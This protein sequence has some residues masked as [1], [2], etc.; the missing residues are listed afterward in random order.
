MKRFLALLAACMLFA[1]PALGETLSY[2]GTVAAAGEVAVMTEMAGTVESVNVSAGDRVEAGAALA[3]IRTEKVYATTD[4]TVTGIFA[5]PGDDL[6]SAVTLYGAVMYIEPSVRYT[7]S[8][9]T[10]RA[11]DSVDMK[12]I[13]V[14]ETV[15]LYCYTHDGT[16]TGTG[17][18]TAVSGSSYTVEVL[19]GVFAIGESVSIF[20]NEECTSAYR[21]GRGTLSRQ[22]PTAVSG[23]GAMVALHVQ[24]GDTVTA[25]QLLFE[26]V[27]GAVTVSEAAEGEEAVPANAITPAAS[28]VVAGV[29]VS[30]G[31]AVEAGAQIATL[32]PDGDM[33]LNV[34]IP[35]S[36]L[37]SVA[38]GT[39]VQI[40]FPWNADGDTLTVGTVESI[41]YV[42]TENDDGSVTFTAG[43]SFTPDERVRVGMSAVAYIE[44]PN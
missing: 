10:D 22:D 14:G 23:T 38:L 28:G 18:V 11:Y 34:E 35:E 7:I 24:D 32:Y 2:D 19:T 16:H 12:Y 25:G 30:A 3:T 5:T 17:R 41:S 1:L 26:S 20:R 21:I 27:T 31:D 29:A 15:Y 40:E 8:A 37:A 39:G 33:L 43:V 13:H 36:D 44:T 6:D 4:G 9:T 42:A